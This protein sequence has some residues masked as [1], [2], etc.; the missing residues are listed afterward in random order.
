MLENSEKCQKNPKKF[1]KISHRSRKC[2]KMQIN[3]RNIQINCFL[4]GKIRKKSEKKSEFPD[5]I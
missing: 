4:A 3:P 5:H 1:L 2:P